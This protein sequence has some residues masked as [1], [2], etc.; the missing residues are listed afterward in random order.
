MQTLAEFKNLIHLSKRQICEEIFSENADKIKVKKPERVVKNLAKIFDATL[1]ISNA[2]GFQAMSLR[3]LSE[4]SGLSMGALYSYFTSKDELVHMI[5]EQGR[6]VTTRVLTEHIEA[7]QGAL[8]QLRA[9]IVAHLYISE[10][11]QPWFY[12]SYMEAK[13]LP[14]KQRK[15][16]IVSELGTEK[17]IS[18]ILIQGQTQ[19]IFRL[20]DPELSAALVKALL[21]DWY[22]KRWKYRSRDISVETYAGT[23]L[24]WVERFVL[25]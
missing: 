18:D 4:A 11:L 19:G 24:E 22:L 9:V 6:R 3:D 10:V 8:E 16:A 23:V 2:K 5:Q 14:K 20:T 25:V 17:L 15:E 13:N 1:S 7:V 12:F 21:Q